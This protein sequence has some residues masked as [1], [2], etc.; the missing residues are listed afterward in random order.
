M[1]LAKIDAQFDL[2]HLRERFPLTYLAPLNNIINRELTAFGRLLAA[3]RA[4]VEDL[5]ANID[6][7]YPRPLEIEALWSSIHQNR[8]PDA[9]LKVS[10]PTARESLADFLVEL[11]LKLKFWTELVEGDGEG[12]PSYWLRAFY[13]PRALLHALI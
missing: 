2:R 13:D 8:V 5:L 3:I 10:F 11:G 1:L 9:W 7:T 12:T 6:G 4:S